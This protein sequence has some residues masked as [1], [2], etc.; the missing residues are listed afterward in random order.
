M[1]SSSDH[2]VNSHH[3]HRL[4]ICHERIRDKGSGQSV[5]HYE[6]S[7]LG[8]RRDL[9]ENRMLEQIN[10]WMQSQGLERLEEY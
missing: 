9:D 3:G 5:L 1:R 8:D 7:Q 4:R 10:V 6:C 2:H